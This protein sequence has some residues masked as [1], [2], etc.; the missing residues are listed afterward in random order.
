MAIHGPLLLRELC[1]VEAAVFASDRWIAAAP[2]GPQVK[3][4]PASCQCPPYHPP[5]IS[6]CA[7]G[8]CTGS[9]EDEAQRPPG[10]DCSGKK[11]NVWLAVLLRTAWAS[12]LHKRPTAL[13]GRDDYVHASLTLIRIPTRQSLDHDRRVQNRIARLSASIPTDIG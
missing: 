13:A 2:F 6:A 7:D 5:G 1:G 11:E 3:G 10:A 9:E 8:D 4:T 12:P